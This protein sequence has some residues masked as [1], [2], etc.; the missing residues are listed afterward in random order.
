MGEINKL[1]LKPVIGFFSKHFSAASQ[2]EDMIRITDKAK[3]SSGDFGEQTVKEPPI[4]D[5]SLNRGKLLIG[6]TIF[7]DDQNIDE[8][9]IKLIA[10]GGFDFLISESG[11]DFQRMLI[12]YCEK[13]GVA[14]ISKDKSLPSGSEIPQ[15]LARG[16]NLFA[17]YEHHPVRVGDTA[18]DEPHASLFPAMGEYYKLF[19]ERFPEQFLFS[20]LFPAGTVSKRLGTK[21]YK[22]YVSEFVKKVPSD[23]IS[24]DEYPFFSLSF[25]KRMAFSLCLETYDIVACACRENNRDFWLYLQTQGNWFDRIYSLPTYEQIKWQ[26][27]TALSYGAKC[28]M[29]ISYTPVWGSD[30]Y[31]MI[32]KKGNVTEQYLYAKRINGELNNLSPVFMRYRNLGVLPSIAKKETGYLKRAFSAQK[33]SSAQ[34]GFSGIECVE[35]IRSDY[36]ALTGYFAGNNGKGYALMLVNCRDLYTPE[37]G[38]E[39]NVHLKYPCT[40]TVYKNGTVFEIKEACKNITVTLESC[41]GAFV[42]I[43]KK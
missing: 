35:K 41:E 20:N 9:D 36:S 10:D 25:L 18:G 32:D 26:V 17:D 16:M 7:Y 42:T 31:A 30:A 4:I 19:S 14:L 39:I 3:V 34:K 11:D 23:F 5:G 1:N 22:E 21:T 29:H 13:Y 15:A 2:N 8:E 27:Y 6:T 28:L 43:D 38:Q 33:K 24:L 12:E 37:A 40:V